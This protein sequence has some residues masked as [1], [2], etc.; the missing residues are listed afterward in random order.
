M[1]ISRKTFNTVKDILKELDDR[2]SQA[3][4]ASTDDEPGRARAVA[5]R[6]RAEDGAEPGDGPRGDDDPARGGVGD[7]L[8]G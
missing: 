7:Q 6:Q 5:K 3:R 1:A 4:P 2:R 8:I